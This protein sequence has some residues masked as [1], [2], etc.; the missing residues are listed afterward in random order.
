M[1]RITY[2]EDAQERDMPRR[3]AQKERLSGA[4]GKEQRESAT[5]GWTMEMKATLARK[6][7]AF[8]PETQR[9]CAEYMRANRA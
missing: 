1:S 7:A 8:S 3:I 5:A 2:L 4:A 9:L 6:L